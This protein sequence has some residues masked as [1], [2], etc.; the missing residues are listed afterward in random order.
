MA[1]GRVIVQSRAARTPAVAAQDVR[2]HAALVEKHVLPGIVQ[3]QPVSPVPPLGRD[4]RPPLFV[5]V[6]GFF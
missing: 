5:G 6:D 1:A 2:R 3:R 4:V